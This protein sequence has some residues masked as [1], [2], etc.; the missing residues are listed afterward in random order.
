MTRKAFQPG[1]CNVMEKILPPKTPG[2]YDG[3][4]ADCEEAMDRAITDLLD[5]ASAAGWSIPEAL[6]AIGRIIP[7]QRRAYEADPDPADE[8]AG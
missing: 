1:H 6:D 7:H 2:L 4:A 3:R 5:R 8:S